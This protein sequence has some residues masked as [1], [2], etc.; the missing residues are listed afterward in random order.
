VIVANM[1]DRLAMI[2]SGEAMIPAIWAM[3]GQEAPF[4]LPCAFIQKIGSPS[5]G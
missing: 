5:R 4:I 1:F 2:L 3:I